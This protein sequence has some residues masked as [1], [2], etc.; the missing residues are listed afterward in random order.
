ME[1]WNRGIVES[2]NRGIVESW[3]RENRGIVNH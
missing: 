1:S 2:W 3:N